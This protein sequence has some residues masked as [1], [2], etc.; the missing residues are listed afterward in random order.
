MNTTENPALTLRLI[1]ELTQAQASA[2][3]G[4]SLSTWKAWEAGRTPMPSKKAT[5]FIAAVGRMDR[6]QVVMAKAG[7]GRHPQIQAGIDRL[8]ELAKDNP[9]PA[10]C[11]SAEDPFGQ[12]RLAALR[13]EGEIKTVTHSG[14]KPEPVADEEFADLNLDG[15][16]A[17]ELP[18]LAGEMRR[19]IAQANEHAESVLSNS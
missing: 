10:P 1:A 16:T 7:G 12:L 8:T 18:V 6:G 15:V 17:E 9:Y 5:A 3:L 14:A 2:L 4:V 19:A 13:D 11:Y